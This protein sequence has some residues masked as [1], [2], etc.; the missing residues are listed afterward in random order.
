MNIDSFREMYTE[1]LQELRCVENQLI[2]ALPGMAD[3]A[4]HPELKQAIQA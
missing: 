4:S 3:T 2:E 1:K